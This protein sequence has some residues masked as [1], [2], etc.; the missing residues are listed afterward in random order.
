MTFT[1]VTLGSEASGVR[2]VM[3]AGLGMSFNHF[4]T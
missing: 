4:L 1:L 2:K 3:V